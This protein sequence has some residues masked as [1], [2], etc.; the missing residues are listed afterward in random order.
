MGCH[1]RFLS[2]HRALARVECQMGDNVGKLRVE[3]AIGD[4]PVARGYPPR[5]SILTVRPR[6]PPLLRG[7]YLGCCALTLWSDLHREVVR[8][9]RQRLLD[10]ELIVGVVDQLEA[11]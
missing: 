8:L 10:L 11:L 9:D 6:R 1:K 5:T 3:C 7:H 2:I 4:F